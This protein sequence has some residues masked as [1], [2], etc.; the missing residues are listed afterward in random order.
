MYY[1]LYNYQWGTLLSKILSVLTYQCLL[2]TV[3]D[4]LCEKSRVTFEG[5]SY[6]SRRERVTCVLNLDK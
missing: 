2:V 6:T 1:H 3:I 4:I 5:V